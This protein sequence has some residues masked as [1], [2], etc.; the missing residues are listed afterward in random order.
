MILKIQLIKKFCGEQSNFVKYLLTLLIFHKEKKRNKTEKQDSSSTANKW[1]GIRVWYWTSLNVSR[2][3]VFS[4]QK[5]K[6]SRVVTFLHYYSMTW[7]VQKWQKNSISTSIKCKIIT[8]EILWFCEG[9]GAK[10]A[11]KAWP[12]EV[13]AKNPRGFWSKL[14]ILV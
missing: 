11:G 5:E 12:T 14:L 1:E 13:D 2:W 8:K 6:F 3:T 4:L 9:W 10:P 7:F